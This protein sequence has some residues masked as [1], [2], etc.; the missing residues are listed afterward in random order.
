M[1]TAS[2]RLPD[3]VIGG[4]QKCGTT[5]LHRYLSAHPALY[6]PRRPQELHFFDFDENF[7]KGI[8]WYA[9]HF[10]LAGHAQKVGQ[11]SPLYLYDERVPSRLAN[12]LPQAR[13][14][15]LLRDPVARAYSHYWHQVKKG[16]ESLPFMDALAMEQERL[17]GGYDAR[18]QYSYVDRGRYVHQ[19]ARFARQFPRTR[20]LVLGTEALGSKPL[21]TL[22][23]CFDFLE[24]DP[25]PAELVAEL[26]AKRF[27]EARLPRWP[28]LQ[29]WV[30]QR[31]SR[32][33]FVASVVDK[34][35]LRRATNPP[36]PDEARAYLIEQLAEDTARLEREFDF[37]TSVWTSRWR[38]R[39]RAA[40][41]AHAQPAGEGE[42]HAGATAF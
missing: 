19:L 1:G 40:T 3:F 26:A 38:S 31:R 11:T 5:S 15:F 28:A 42:A 10:K 34:L 41:G 13:L 39:E 21:D 36:M 6:L 22:R 35:N 9:G 33:P 32:M 25:L 27:N 14:I 2:H 8:D 18:R 29:Q 12:A 7:A 30:G 16:T 20:M 24:V 4:A 23:L 17:R 37:D